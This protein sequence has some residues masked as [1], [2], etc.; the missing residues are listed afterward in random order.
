MWIFVVL[1]VLALLFVFGFAVSEPRIG[2]GRLRSGLPVF[3]IVAIWLVVL[4]AIMLLWP[5]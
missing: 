4:P 1:L 2:E 3:I 5:H